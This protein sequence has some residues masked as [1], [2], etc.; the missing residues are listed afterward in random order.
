MQI[1]MVLMRIYNQHATVK[2]IFYIPAI[3]WIVF[4]GRELGAQFDL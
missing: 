3:S 4:G 2:A 1:K